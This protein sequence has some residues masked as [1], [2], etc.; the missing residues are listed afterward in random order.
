MSHSEDQPFV[1]PLPFERLAQYNQWMN[2]KLYGA[3]MSLSEEE[4]AAERGAFFGSILG[5]LN[6]L[7]VADLIWLGRFHQHQPSDALLPLESFRTPERLDELYHADIALLAH[8]RQRLDEMI[9]HWIQGLNEAA[10]AQVMHYRNTRGESKAFAFEEVLL[11]FF[12]HQTHH[13]GQATTLLTQAGVDVG[14]TDMLAILTPA[15]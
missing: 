3:V 2:A 10:F 9:L 12:N 5:T 1:H 13:R 14:V 11:H 7:L 15:Q 4:I 6:H 8:D